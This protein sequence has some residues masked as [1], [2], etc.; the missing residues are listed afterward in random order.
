MDFNLTSEQK[1]VQSVVHK[2]AETE[3]KPIAQELDATGEFPWPVI[4]K[5]GQINLMGMTVPKELGGA[6][7]DYISYAIAIDILRRTQAMELGNN[8]QN[9]SWIYE[10]KSIFSI[11]SQSQKEK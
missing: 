2:F 10:T 6:G 3:I 9:H 5:M 8:H 11:H 7:V 1:M 4:K